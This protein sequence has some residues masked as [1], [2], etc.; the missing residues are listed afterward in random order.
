MYEYSAKIIAVIDGDT[1]K[2]EIDLGFGITRRDTLRLKGIN[3]PEL[4]AADPK[5]GIAAKEY[6]AKLLSI[7]PTVTIRTHKDASEKYG[8]LLAEIWIPGQHGEISSVNSEMVT[9]GH[10]KPYDGGKRD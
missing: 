7:F 10:A 4:H 1:V 8:R 2:A 6:L 9:A 3:A 5:P